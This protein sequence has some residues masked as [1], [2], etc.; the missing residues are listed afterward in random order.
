[1]PITVSTLAEARYFFAHGVTD[2]LYAVGIAQVK[3]P[4]VADLILA[5][6]KLRVIAGTLPKLRTLCA[7]SPVTD[8]STSKR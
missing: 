8:A 4:E 7:R 1:M 5:G 6:C 2:I 3:L